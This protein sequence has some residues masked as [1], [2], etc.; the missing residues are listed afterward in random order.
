MKSKFITAAEAKAIS[1]QNESVGFTSIMDRVEE[2]ATQGGKEFKISNK[3]LFKKFEAELL[4]LGY[5]F[6]EKNGESI[7]SWDIPDKDGK[8]SHLVKN[9]VPVYIDLRLMRNAI[10]G[11]SGTDIKYSINDLIELAL[12]KNIVIGESEG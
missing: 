8:F 1:K 6:K 4:S 12:K 11:L 5:L 9:D 3:P 10:A 2:C 7:L